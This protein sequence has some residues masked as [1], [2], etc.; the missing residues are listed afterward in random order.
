M[1]FL[2]AHADLVEAARIATKALHTLSD[3]S[4]PQQIADPGWRCLQVRLEHSDQ[5]ADGHEDRFSQLSILLIL[6]ACG[7]WVRPMLLQHTICWLWHTTA[8]KLCSAAAL[9]FWQ[10]RWS[11]ARFS[12]LGINQCFVG[13]VVRLTMQPVRRLDGGRVSLHHRNLAGQRLTN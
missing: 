3:T 10:S 6:A 7:A 4:I 9:R 2:S 13:V 5:L 12:E 1:L 11:A 8:G